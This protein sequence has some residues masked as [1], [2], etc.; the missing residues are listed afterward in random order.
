MGE[1]VY[2]CVPPGGDEV[3]DS[4]EVKGQPFLPHVHSYTHNNYLMQHL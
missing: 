1:A 2:T 4:P 3:T